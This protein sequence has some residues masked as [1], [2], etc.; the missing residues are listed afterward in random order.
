MTERVRHQPSGAEKRAEAF[1]GSGLIAEDAAN[2]PVPINNRVRCCPIAKPT[3][4]QDE[5]L[6]TSCHW[7]EPT[8]YSNVSGTVPPYN[9]GGENK[10]HFHKSRLSKN[11]LAGASSKMLN[12]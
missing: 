4:G 9:L 10:M 7:H 2:I 12:M 11:S 1:P 6:S 3:N 8:C 5:D